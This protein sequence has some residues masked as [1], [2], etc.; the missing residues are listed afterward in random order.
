M[1]KLQ[2]GNP[3]ILQVVGDEISNLENAIESIF[4]LETEYLILI[5]NYIFIPLSYKYDLSLMVLDLI[6]VLCFLER[7]G[8]EELDLHWASNT[9]A[10]VWKLKKMDTSVSIKTTCENV[11]GG[12]KTLL[13][14][15][16]E[17]SIGS[18]E[19]KTEIKKLLLFLK[20][21]LEKSGIN[22]SKIDDYMKLECSLL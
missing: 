17:V 6:E 9:F 19:L 1:F 10:C 18:S 2:L 4:P 13:D 21:S 5:W 3:I 16:N 22:I 8:D 12:V 20:Q 14:N 15:C 7:K 11:R